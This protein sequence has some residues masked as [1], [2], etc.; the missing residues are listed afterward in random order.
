MTDLR[1]LVAEELGLPVEPRVSGVAAVIAAKH[2]AV[3]RG[4]VLWL[5]PARKAA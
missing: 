5:V 3:S 4:A 1:T 2:G